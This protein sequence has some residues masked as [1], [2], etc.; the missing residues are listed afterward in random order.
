MKPLCREACL[1]LC[2]VCGINL[3]SERCSCETSWRDP[4]LA[5]LDTLFSDSRK[6]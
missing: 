3:N 5:N 2:P 6:V 4:R 1:G